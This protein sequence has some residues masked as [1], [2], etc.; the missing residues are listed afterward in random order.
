MPHILTAQTAALPHALR[1]AASP[2]VLRA[3]APGIVLAEGAQIAAPPVFLRHICPAEITVPLTGTLSDIAALS[4]AAA[5]LCQRLDSAR[6]VSVQARILEGVNLDYKPFDVNTA[7]SKAAMAT[8]APLDVKA[9]AQIISVTLANDAGYLGLSTPRENLSDWAGGMRRFRQEPGQI[10]R[11]EFKLLEALETFAVPL[12]QAGRALDLGAAP[13]GWTR[14]LRQRGMT[15]TAVDPAELDPRITA[16]PGVTHARMTAERYFAGEPI[17][18]DLL[19]ND[20][21]MDAEPSAAL[22]VHGAR[23]L[24][25]GGAGILTLKLPDEA[26]TWPRRVLAARGWLE[27]AYQIAGM[28]QLFHNRSEVTVY[29]TKL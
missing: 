3:L 23:L 20:M 13:G 1:E 8:G 26:A 2:R 11:A 5:G 17:P 14:V 27:K 24:K 22:M 6:S 21:K 7:L 25:S 29:L 18:C 4:R 15:V 12:P 28:R 19:V 10:S 9:P 16:D